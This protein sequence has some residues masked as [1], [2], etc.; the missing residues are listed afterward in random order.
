M[1]LRL[2]NGEDPSACPQDL[3]AD[4]ILSLEA[5]REH[6]L[7]G[8][9][10]ELAERADK[11]LCALQQF[12]KDASREGAQ[13][14]LE[15]SYRA[16]LELAWKADAELRERAEQTRENIRARNSEELARLRE[17]HEAEL[18]KFTSR[19][20]DPLF[21]KRYNRAS[22]HLSGLRRRSAILLGQRKYEE[23]RRTEMEVQATEERERNEQFRAMVMSYDQQLKHI[24]QRHANEIEML[25][26]AHKR[27]E[28]QFSVTADI[29]DESALKRVSVLELKLKEVSNPEVVW[30]RHHRFEGKSVGRSMAPVKLGAVLMNPKE[31]AL[32]PLP[33]ISALRKPPPKGKVARAHTPLRLSI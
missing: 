31:I 25:L 13:R 7:R 33:P 21:L 9:E 3:V 6:H 1:A 30:N 4:V 22:V 24:Q 17:R 16:R 32:L 28:E 15:E 27:R 26:E 11:S 14:D 23:M 10:S 5:L 8:H 2:M 20:Q 29:T 19:W 12:Q 18:A